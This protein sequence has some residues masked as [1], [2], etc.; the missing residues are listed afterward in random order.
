MPSDT[1]DTRDDDITRHDVV[2]GMVFKSRHSRP[3]RKLFFVLAIER[4][5]RHAKI[6]YLI[7]EQFHGCVARV[8]QYTGS[9]Y[10]KVW[11]EFDVVW[12]PSRQK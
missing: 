10:E 1:E 8:A 11:S 2:P 5:D 12:L 6:T 7:A 9:L 4:T 3:G